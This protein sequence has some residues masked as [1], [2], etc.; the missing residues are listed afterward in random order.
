V[1]GV[2]LS[3]AGGGC[4]WGFGR[5]VYLGGEVIPL[6]AFEVLDHHIAFAIGVEFHYVT[7]IMEFNSMIIY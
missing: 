2:S 5:G 7:F 3:G 1:G 6:W 4:G